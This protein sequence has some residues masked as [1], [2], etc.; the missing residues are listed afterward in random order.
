MPQPVGDDEHLARFAFSK[1]HFRRIDNTIKPEALLPTPWTQLSVTRHL[2]LS[3]TQI[4]EV[5]C[6]IARVGGA[7][8]ELTLYGRADI[9]AQDA[10]SLGLEVNPDEPP[11]NHAN[12]EPWPPEEAAQLILAQ[13]LVARNSTFIP[14]PQEINC[15]AESDSLSSETRPSL[16]HH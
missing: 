15:S 12:I 14:K 7:G 5:G 8:R 11:P 6:G 2:G 13:K 4:W 1:R 9:L 3:P 10:R 16:E